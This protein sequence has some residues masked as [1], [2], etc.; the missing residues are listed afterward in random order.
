MMDKR[1]RN[2]VIDGGGTAG[3]MAAASLVKFLENMNVGIR[4]VESEQIGIVGVGEATIPPIID[5]IRGL[6][7]DE[8]DIVHQIKATFKLGIA[9]RDWTRSRSRPIWTISAPGEKVRRRHA[10]ASGFHR[11]ELFDR[12]IPGATNGTIEPR[13]SADSSLCFE[14][15]VPPLDVESPQLGADLIRPP[16]CPS[17]K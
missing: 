17:P 4:L 16:K 1:I 5:F 2:V 10:A 12:R 9:Y 11:K 15:R 3:W 8:N 6:G 7:I 14:K 13:G